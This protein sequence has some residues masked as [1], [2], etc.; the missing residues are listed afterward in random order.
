VTQTE[1]DARRNQTIR[2][3]D[4]RTLGFAEY[5]DPNGA[6]LLFFHGTP[7]SRLMAV[8]EWD[9]TSLGIRLIA[10]DRPGIGLSDYLPNRTIQSWADDVRELGDAL[11]LD[12]FVVAGVSGGG[13]HSLAC[14]CKLPDRVIRAGV[15]SGAAPMDTPEALAGM[16]T[17]NR[18]AFKLANRAPIVLRALFGV[19]SYVA[20][21]KPDA[22]FGDKGLP[23]A[24]REIMK[25][26]ALRKA[27]MAE[28]P[29]SYR[30]GS[31][32]IADEA[33]MFT[34]PWGF[35]MEDITVPVLLWHGGEDRNAPL[36]MAKVMERRIPDC[37]ATYYETEG[38]LYFL[39][40][41]PEL[42]RAL[43]PKD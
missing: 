43:V 20:K 8:P 24:D 38:H 16:H 32:A 39:K 6:P 13:P 10:P 29:E 25:D 15:I 27:L 9:D 4:G 7:G 22:N 36:A 34:K 33:V 11:A 35:R 40:R 12:R 31:R 19:M 28:A 1:Q 14:A 30:Q 26:T 21:K 37:T 42:A 2:L 18:I 5:G 17:G 23:P 41:W 3:R